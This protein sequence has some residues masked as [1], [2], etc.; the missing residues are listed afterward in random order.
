MKPVTRLTRET[1]NRFLDMYRHGKFPSQ[2]LGQAAV[3]HFGLVGQSYLFYQIS[4][5]KVCEHVES[6]MHDYQL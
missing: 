4:E 5:R 3:N 2:R 6:M 1:W